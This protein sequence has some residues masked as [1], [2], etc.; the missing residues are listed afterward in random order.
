MVDMYNGDENR[1]RVVWFEMLLYVE[2]ML[3]L[4]VLL[5]FRL[6][7]RKEIVYRIL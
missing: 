6:G 5:N 2:K 1:S 4:W 3:G 7:F